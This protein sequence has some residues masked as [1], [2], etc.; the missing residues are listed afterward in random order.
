M[1]VVSCQHC[2]R[3]SYNPD[4]A[5]IVHADDCIHHLAVAANDAE[6]ARGFGPEKP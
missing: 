3:H 6:R 4:P 2:R 1:P 5:T